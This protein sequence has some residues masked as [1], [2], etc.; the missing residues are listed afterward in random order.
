[1]MS[2]VTDPLEQMRQH[3]MLSQQAAYFRPLNVVTPLS[4]NFYANTAAST[5]QN[6]NGS[7]SKLIAEEGQFI[8][9]WCELPY[10]TIQ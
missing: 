10:N 7:L 2:D 3:Q 1:M 4:D 5:T 6:F 9:Y 8:L